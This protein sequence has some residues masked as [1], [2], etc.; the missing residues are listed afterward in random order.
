MSVEIL[1]SV[2]SKERTQ[3]ADEKSK[4]GGGKPQGPGKGGVR[5]A[6]RTDSVEKGTVIK[7]PK[8]PVTE[9]INVPKPPRPSG[10]NK[11]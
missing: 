5:E 2:N 6:P 10:T 11:K 3:M 7:G 8:G 9:A 1:L 4:A